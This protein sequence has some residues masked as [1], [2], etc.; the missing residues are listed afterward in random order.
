LDE[1]ITNKTTLN[2]SGFSEKLVE[3]SNKDKNTNIVSPRDKTDFNPD[4]TVHPWFAHFHDDAKDKFNAGTQFKLSGNFPDG[5][6]GPVNFTGSLKGDGSDSPWTPKGIGIHERIF[7]D[8]FNAKE[9]VGRQ[10]QLIETFS[11]PEPSSFI[12][13]GLGVATVGYA[14]RRRKSATADQTDPMVQA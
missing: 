2:W 5:A 11:T 7:G 9:K 8:V 1:N 6:A 12:L 14:W 3:V 10:F 4:K 13:L